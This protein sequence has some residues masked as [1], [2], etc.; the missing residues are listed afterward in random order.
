MTWARQV[1]TKLL[2]IGVLCGALG[3]THKVLGQDVTSVSG[4]LDQSDQ[5]QGLD[6]SFAQ[7]A[8]T[9]G[10][11][12]QQGVIDA[13]HAQVNQQVSGVVSDYMAIGQATSSYTDS[14]VQIP[15]GGG[16]GKGMA[17]ASSAAF[18]GR[19]A[20]MQVSGFGS[21][22][23]RAAFSVGMGTA[24][25]EGA[26]V[27]PSG[28]RHES[29]ADATSGA[30]VGAI[31]PVLVPPGGI[32]QADLE[33][34]ASPPAPSGTV[35]ATFATPSLLAPTYQYDD[36]QTPLLGGSGSTPGALLGTAAGYSDSP[37]GFPDSTLGQAALPSEGTVFGPPAGLVAS[38]GTGSPFP[39]VSD[40]GVF[41]I[42]AGVRPTLHVTTTIA[43][44]S[45]QTFEAHERRLFN[46]RIVSGMS[47]SQ[48][49]WLRRA[50]RAKYLNNP[51]SSLTTSGSATGGSAADT[52]GDSVIR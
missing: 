17:D 1:Q 34:G 35:M 46:K 37:G 30:A 4:S 19:T 22:S 48:A 52:V 38:I 47:V 42:K 14:M 12:T 2:A 36:G 51:G 28:N 5:T 32:N 3:C 25:G 16:G 41:T 44:P 40:G 43:A 13:T 50:D 49:E 24:T 9:I 23:D 29:G 39:P 26:G 15:G 6:S 20:A 33:L 8:G 21:A 7:G 18:G 31:D 45:M 10:A 27:L 11:N